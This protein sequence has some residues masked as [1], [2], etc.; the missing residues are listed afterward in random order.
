MKE[1]PRTGDG[2]NLYHIHV[3]QLVPCSRSAVNIADVQLTFSDRTMHQSEQK[4]W[5]KPQ[6]SIEAENKRRFPVPAFDARSLP[7]TQFSLI[8]GGEV[9]RFFILKTSNPRTSLYLYT[10]I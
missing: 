8:H 6:D 5:P 2:L 10:R 4:G 1:N 3:L 7:P 9:A